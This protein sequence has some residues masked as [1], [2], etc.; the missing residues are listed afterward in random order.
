M[1]VS[2]ENGDSSV[3]GEIAKDGGDAGSVLG[4]G[5]A[6]PPGYWRERKYQQ[7]TCSLASS[8]M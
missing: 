4:A 1:G 3:K 5:N 6:V 7:R 8:R 2:V